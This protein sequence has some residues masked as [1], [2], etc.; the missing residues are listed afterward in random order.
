MH[1][2]HKAHFLIFDPSPYCWV[3]GSMIFSKKIWLKFFSQVDIVVSYWFPDFEVFWC[4]NWVVWSWRNSAW[5]A[6]LLLPAPNGPKFES[7]IP[8]SFCTKTPQIRHINSW[9]LCLA[10]KKI[11]SIYF[12]KNHASRYRPDV[13]SDFFFRI[14]HL[15]DRRRTHHFGNC[16]KNKRLGFA[17]YAAIC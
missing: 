15:Y 4:K 13:M 1:N 5:T 8:L 3:L 11:S 14:R 7:F 16:W 9:L 2:F 10:V 12:W 6:I 17:I